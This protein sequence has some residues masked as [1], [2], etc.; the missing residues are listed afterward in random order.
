MQPNNRFFSSTRLAALTGLAA[1]FLL[2]GCGGDSDSSSLTPVTGLNNAGVVASVSSDFSSGAVNVIDLDSA[3]YDAFGPYHETQSDIAVVGG[4]GHYYL[5]GRF[6]MDNISKVEI[7]NLAQKTWDEFSVLRQGEQDAGNPYDLIKVND[8]KGYL[9]RYNSADVLIVNPSATVEADFITGSLDLS[10][11]APANNTDGLPRVSAAA[12]AG[13]RLFITVQRLDTNYQPVNTSYVAV[14]DVSN[15]TEINTGKGT[16]DNLKGIP[17][18]GTNPDDIQYH[19]GIG[20]VVRNLG[21][22]FPTYGNGTSLDVINPADYTTSSMIPPTTTDADGQLLDVV[23]VNSN[24]GYIV[25]LAG[26]QNT[27]VQSFNPATGRTDLAT[28]G[29]FSGGDFRDIELSPK[30]NL[31]I[32]DAN[33]QTPGIHIVNTSDDSVIT[34]VDSLRGLLPNNIAFV[35]E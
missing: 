10:D 34:F 7:S 28:I 9:V 16:A 15:D 32:A 4:K 29:S 17:L 33:L 27:S 18:L 21:T 22:N 12:L 31:W 6:N 35:T 1:A 25:N 19:S 5:M 30:G 24:L 14:F 26:Y 2:S 11:Y 3:N 8:Q 13:N 20:L 23:I